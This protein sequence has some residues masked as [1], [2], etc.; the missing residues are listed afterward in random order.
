MMMEPVTRVDHGPWD[1]PG[2]VR[3]ELEGLE[4]E[5]RC[6]IVPGPLSLIPTS[7]SARSPEP[8]LDQRGRS[9]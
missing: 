8:L 4:D 3:E 9:R 7:P 6:P 1:E 5:V 2:Q